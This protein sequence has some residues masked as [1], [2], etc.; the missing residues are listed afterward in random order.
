[1]R[2]T[3][4]TVRQLVEAV[5]LADREDDRGGEDTGGVT[6]D[7]WDALLA[8]PPDPALA[9]NLGK[10]KTI[11]AA[12]IYVALQIL[13]AIARVLFRFRAT[14]LEHMPSDGPFMI[15]PNHQA[16]IDPGFLVAVLPFRTMRQFYAV[17]AAEYFATPLSA[18]IAHAINIVPV[19]ADANLV[20]AMRAA[21]T[22]LRIGK[23]LVLFPEGERSIDGEVKRFRRGAAILSAQLQ[24]PIVPVALD[25]LY[26]LWPRGRR[27][28]WAGLLPWRSRPITLR[29]GPPI[30]VASGAYH[31]GTATLQRTVTT[32][33]GEIRAAHRPASRPT[34]TQSP[35]R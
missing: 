16:Y 20:N 1:V 5:E 27:L 35:S 32:L 33:L 19:D 23:V 3:I 11:R 17:G 6:D 12:G 34:T 4:F 28:D 10:D 25:G 18:R 14:G 21:A 26:E 15:C 8:Q 9:T 2:A 30:Q 22:G 31:E 13:R 29:F 7:A 24:V